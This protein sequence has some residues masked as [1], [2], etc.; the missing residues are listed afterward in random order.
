MVSSEVFLAVDVAV[1]LATIGPVLVALEGDMGLLL[2]VI[3]A[4][5]RCWRVRGSRLVVG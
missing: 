4:V 2:P 1:P 3:D 5:A